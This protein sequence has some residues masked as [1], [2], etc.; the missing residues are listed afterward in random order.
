VISTFLH[1]SGS[2][3]SNFYVSE[4]EKKNEIRYP[5]TQIIP[6]ARQIRENKDLGSGISM[7]C[8]FCV[9]L[10]VCMSERFRSIRFSFPLFCLGRGEGTERNGTETEMETE[11][12][13]KEIVKVY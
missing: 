6:T 11:E 2:A 5:H 7:A 10:R 9:G 3:L 12:F 13:A 1:W 4:K 8:V